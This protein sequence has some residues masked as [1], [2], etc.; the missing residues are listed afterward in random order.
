MRFD[1]TLCFLTRADRVLMLHRRRPPNRGLWNGVGGHIEAGEAPLAACLRE[2]REE[3]GYRLASARFAG[4]LTWRGFEVPDGGL[5][6]FTA[7]APPDEPGACAEG[8]LRWQALPWVLSSP[9]VVSNIVYF[10][11]QVLA[12]APPRRHHFD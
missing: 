9:E 5:Y 11:P 6:V 4:V 8:V 7:A 3:T 12:G 2:V 1:Y 10:A